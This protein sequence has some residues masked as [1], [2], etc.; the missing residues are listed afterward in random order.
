MPTATERAQAIIARNG[1]LKSE[2]SNFDAIAGGVAEWSMPFYNSIN[3]SSAPGL[4]FAEK[5]YDGTLEQANFVCASGMTTNTSPATGSWFGLEAPAILRARSG[6]ANI[7]DEWYQQATE[8][9]QRELSLSNF[10]T[11]IFTV[12]QERG[13]MPAGNLMT[14]EG[15]DCLLNFEAIPYGS[16]GIARSGKGR[17]DTVYR[18]WQLS[19]RQAKQ[20]F[21]VDANGR[22]IPGA[23]GPKLAE[24]ANSPEAKKRDTLFNFIQAVYPRADADRDPY[25]RTGENKPWASCTVCVEDQ[26]LVRESGYDENPFAVSSWGKIAGQ[27]WGW[28]PGM[29][30]L[31]IVRQLNFS[32]KQLDLA[33]E[34]MVDPRV[35]VP[36]SMWGSVHFEAGGLTPWDENNPNGKPEEWMTGARVDMGMER[37]EQRRKFIKDAFHGDLWQMFSGLERD[38]TA[39][40]ASKMDGE[41]LD[42]IVPIVHGITTELLGPTILRAFGMCYRAGFLPPAPREVMLPYGLDANGREVA[43]I[44]TPQVVYTSKMSVAI[45]L[46]EN[47]G[48]T[49]FMTQWAPLAEAKPDLLD[50]INFEQAVPDSARNHL[51]PSRW[52]R[53]AEAVAEMQAQRAKQAEAQQAAAMLESTS[54]SAANMGK[55]SAPVQAAAQ[56][57]MGM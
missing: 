56:Q 6:G 18:E 29:R 35:L 40:Q 12:H 21:G 57:A 36:Q 30:V 54:K 51:V 52:I 26:H 15:D 19:A 43:A 38:I 44:A 10:Y 11:E 46:L 7:A 9:V 33:I 50:F 55:A 53:S 32:E 37:A 22:E 8:I 42:V 25:K 20:E 4:T 24:A 45:K 41:K 23:L 17:V 28:S 3:P 49:D 5:I 47:R 39:Y 31:P 48:L 2:R 1:S 13:L 27:V 16:Y 34:K 14:D